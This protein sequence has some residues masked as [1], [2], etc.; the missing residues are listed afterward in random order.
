MGAI[1]SFF[2]GPLGKIAMYAIAALFAA[3][4][5][6]AAWHHY[7][8]LVTDVATLKQQNAQLTR[9]LVDQQK[10]IKDAQDLA[11]LTNK[12]LSTLQGS[13][14]ATNQ[15]FS[16]IENFLNTPDEQKK[17]RPASDLLKDTIRKLKEQQK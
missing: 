9:T 1:L 14:D 10:S 8:I 17:D 7:D 4:L 16:D 11:D 12:S 15:K 5:I 2:T 13:V 3:G 6:W